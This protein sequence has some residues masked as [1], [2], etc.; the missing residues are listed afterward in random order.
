MDSNQTAPITD[1]Y[2]EP[3]PLAKE[4][5]VSDRTLHRWYVERIGPPRVTIGR[6][7][8]YRREAVREW[9]RSREETQPR[10]RQRT[11]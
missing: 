2:I 1:E 5:G 4:L 3:S 10:S 8:L 9:L 6:K 7:V 11:A